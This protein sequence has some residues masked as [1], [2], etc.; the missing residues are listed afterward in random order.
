MLLVKSHMRDIEKGKDTSFSVL[1]LTMAF[2]DIV[3]WKGMWRVVKTCDVELKS[4]LESLAQVV[5]C[6]YSS[7]LP[8]MNLISQSIW[9][10]LTNRI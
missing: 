1:A 5:S 10:I 7:F 6:F 4:K 3:Y 2:C 8:S 9:L